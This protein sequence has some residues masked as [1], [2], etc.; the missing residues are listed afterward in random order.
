MA[1][2]QYPGWHKDP[3]GVWR[4]P[5]YPRGGNHPKDGLSIVYDAEMNGAV[6][7]VDGHISPFSFGELQN[8][9]EQLLAVRRQAQDENSRL[10][11]EKEQIMHVEDGIEPAVYVRGIRQNPRRK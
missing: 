6:L 5:R 9:N 4:N 7:T 3:D 10:W 1:E 8:L 2:Q 11:K